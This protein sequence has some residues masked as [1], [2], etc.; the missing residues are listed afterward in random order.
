MSLSGNAALES[1][2]GLKV[3]CE[4]RGKKIVF[5][6][7]KELGGTD[8]GMNPIEGLLTSLGAC[9]C[10]VAKVAADK[11]G[12]KLDSIEVECKGTLDT[13]GFTGT[14]PDAKV[15]LSDIQSVFSIKSPAS[16]EEIKNLVDFVN[17]HCPVHDTIDSP[18]PLTHTIKR[19]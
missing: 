19:V 2:S 15:G 5:D 3:N 7:P 9:K 11:M 13:G 18:P 1:T 8:T 4:A 16:D 10:I 14:N 6:E 12:I 17:S